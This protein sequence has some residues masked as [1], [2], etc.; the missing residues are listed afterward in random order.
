MPVADSQKLTVQII[1]KGLIADGGSG[2][3]PCLNVYNYRR[4]SGAPTLNK[5][6]VL[7]A[8]NTLIENKIENILH[9]DY[10]CDELTARM[11]EDNLDAE[12]PKTVTWIGVRTGDR[13][14]DFQCFTF[15]L[16]SALRGRSYRGSKH[17]S[18]ISESD[19]DKDVVDAGI[20]ADISALETALAAGFTDSDGN[21]WSPV[22]VSWTLSSLSGDLWTISAAA[23][24]TVTANQQLGTVNSRKRS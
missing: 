23:I 22:V 24:T 20:A 19:T 4:P 3:R 6:N 21:T 1:S 5:A 10:T 18:P 9:P 17:Y 7:T 8:F 16:K 15:Q 14:P 2:V 11:L 12:T 13:A